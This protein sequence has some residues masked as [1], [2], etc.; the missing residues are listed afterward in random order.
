MISAQPNSRLDGAMYLSR[1]GGAPANVAVGLARLGVSAGFIGSFSDDQWGRLLLQQLRE[2]KVNIS[3]CTVTTDRQTR[4]TWVV[5]ES[6][7]QQ[8]M[9]DFTKFSCADEALSPAA[10]RSGLFESAEAFHFGSLCQRRG[11]A[12]NATTEAIGLAWRQGL[13][14]SYD[15]NVRLALWSNDEACRQTIL[16]TLKYV[17]LVK[18]SDNELRFLTGED[19]I[20]AAKSLKEQ[21]QI[22]LLVITRSERGALFLHG[23]RV[24]SIPGFEVNVVD[25]TGAGEAFNASMIAGLL[26]HLHSREENGLTR[27]EQL[28]ALP[29]EKL[30]KIVRRANAAGAITCTAFGAIPTLP[31]AA[32]VD[33]LLE[34]Q[35]NLASLNSPVEDEYLI[36]EP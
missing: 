20:I 14:I 18:I 30:E 28:E 4:F 13:L 5:T 9:A 3:S 33:L 26:Q 36:R 24:R 32:A 29:T 2:E 34:G 31:T 23:G 22:P 15:P 17:D 35:S 1:P 12:A 6:K 16:N 27:R 8:P 19:S 10:L 21:H 7:S 11:P 25:V